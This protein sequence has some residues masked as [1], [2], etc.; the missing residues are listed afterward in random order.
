[1]AMKSPPEMNPLSGR[2]PE[3]ISESLEMGFARRRLWKVFRIVALG[4]ASYGIHYTGYPR[5]L[6][7]YSDANW[8]SDADETKATSGYLFTLGGGAV[9]WKSC[10]Q[11]IIMRSTMEAELTTLDTA[12]LKQ[13]GYVSS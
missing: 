2:V 10:K 9:S 3:A 7:G 5:V 13:S 4:T 1:M 11:T 12:M 6:E 8:I